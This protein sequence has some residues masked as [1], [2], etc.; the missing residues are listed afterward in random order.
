MTVG[1]SAVFGGTVGGGSDTIRNLN[2]T[3]ATAIGAGALTTTG[4][5]T[6]VGDVRLNSGA[7]LASTGDV[8]WGHRPIA[9]RPWRKLTRVGTPARAAS[10][11][12]SSARRFSLGMLA[13]AS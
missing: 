12:T 3:G 4:T 6:D 7:V 9:G 1:G 11:G 2:V 5:Q 10:S 13:G 8:L